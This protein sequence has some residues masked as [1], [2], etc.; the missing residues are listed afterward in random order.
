MLATTQEEK[1]QR[2]LVLQGFILTLVLFFLIAL[3]NRTI[4]SVTGMSEWSAALFII[5][6]LFYWLWLTSIYIYV[7]RL[8]RNPLLLWTEKRYSSGFYF[9]SIFGILFVLAVGNVAVTYSLYFSGLYKPNSILASLGL[10]SFPLKLFISLT[11]GIVEESVMRGYL[12][13]R[14][15]LFFKGKYWPVILS[16]IIFGLAHIRWG[17]LANVLVPT[18]IGVIFALHY[19]KYRNIKVLIAC[20]FLWDLIG[21]MMI[22][23]AAK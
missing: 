8:E 21:F 19:Q 17:T 20:H 1:S 16:S 22:S 5:S 14:I 10:F 12:M 13:P 2:K 6:R 3:A 9:A 7:T 23:H 18:F 15:Q 4:S 11:A